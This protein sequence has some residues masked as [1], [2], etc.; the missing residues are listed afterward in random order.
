MIYF[1]FLLP[2][3]PQSQ[4]SVL[5]TLSASYLSSAFVAEQ[6]S[7]CLFTPQ[8]SCEILSYSKDSGSSP[9]TVSFSLSKNEIEKKVR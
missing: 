7:G 6:C 4:Q 1:F 3:C 8:L 9:F 5:R 2:V